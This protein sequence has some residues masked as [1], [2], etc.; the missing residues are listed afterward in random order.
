MI[1]LLVA[2]CVEPWNL[3]VVDLDKPGPSCVLPKREGEVGSASPSLAAVSGHGS[4]LRA[5]LGPHRLSD[6]VPGGAGAEF[7]V[8]A[9]ARRPDGSEVTEERV[10]IG[11]EAG[12]LDL[13]LPELFAE[14]AVG[15]LGFWHPER[16]G[17]PQD[18]PVRVIT[19]QPDAILCVFPAG[20][21]EAWKPVG[22]DEVVTLLARTHRA[23]GRRVR[24]EI[25][26][27]LDLDRNVL[28]PSSR[29]PV[30]EQVAVVEGVHA[31]IEWTV[32]PTVLPANFHIEASV[33]DDEGGVTASVMDS[34][35][36]HDEGPITALF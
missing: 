31:S 8:T 27:L 1:A 16:I 25:H 6:R 10:A 35:T 28:T 20:D 21:D 18:V 26:E 29:V 19:D 17:R 5:L 34:V 32:S 11:D 9:S 7:T 36:V 15:T 33:L 30:L 3:A 24:F 22:P 2:A 23:E 14:P 12:G 13:D 4:A